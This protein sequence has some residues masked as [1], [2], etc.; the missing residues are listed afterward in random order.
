M[1]L[2]V[3]SLSVYF[4]LE[5]MMLPYPKIKAVKPL[6]NYRLLVSFQNGEQKL[7]DCSPLLE[8]AV[9]QPLKNKTFFKA[10]R[11]DP[12][13]YGI[14][15]SEE[16]DLAESDRLAS[17]SSQRLNSSLSVARICCLLFMRVLHDQ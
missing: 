10:V 1:Q 13:G 12:G 14:S 3:T 8:K 6:K 16:I 9:F 17:S 7:Y 11:A 5:F 2:C 15:W 4:V